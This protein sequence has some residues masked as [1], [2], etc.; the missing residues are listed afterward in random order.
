M[1][2]TA[3]ISETEAE[4]DNGRLVPVTIAECSRCHHE[5]T[6][7]GTTSAS[8]RRCLVMLREECPRSE[9]NFYVEAE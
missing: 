3:N 6:S 8:L 2:I 9:R 4:N 5:T 7:Y 1:K